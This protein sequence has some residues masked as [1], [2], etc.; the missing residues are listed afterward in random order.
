[1]Q[2]PCTSVGQ[3]PK[4]VVPVT[5]STIEPLVDCALILVIVGVAVIVGVFRVTSQHSTVVLMLFRVVWPGVCRAADALE[6]GGWPCRRWRNPS[7]RPGRPVR[8]GATGHGG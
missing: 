2:A 3:L 8:P 6:N 4:R 7:P 1:M 5:D